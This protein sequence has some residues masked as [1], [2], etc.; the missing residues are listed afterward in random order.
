MP[1]NERP[2]PQGT[3]PDGSVIRLD[4]RT[5]TVMVTVDAPPDRMPHLI[6]HASLGLDR[7]PEYSGFLAGALHLDE[8]GTRMVQYLQWASAE[9]YRACVEDPAWDE[10]PSTRRFQKAVESGDA[11]LDVRILEVL[12]VSG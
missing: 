1:R 3:S 10:L 4:P 2:T 8:A 12:K 11:R 6:E 7:F 5:C 9:Q